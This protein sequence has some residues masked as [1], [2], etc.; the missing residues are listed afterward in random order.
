MYKHNCTHPDAVELEPSTLFCVHIFIGHLEQSCRI[1]Q[2]KDQQDEVNIWKYQSS[3]VQFTCT[4]RA[5][6]IYCTLLPCCILLGSIM[7]D[8]VTTSSIM[9]W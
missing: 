2:T 8:I 9:K 3:V 6:V 5:S 1:D 7:R 4:W